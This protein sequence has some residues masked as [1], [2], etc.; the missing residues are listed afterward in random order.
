MPGEEI[1]WFPGHMLK[2]KKQIL[3][4]VRDVDIVVELLD[5]RAPLATQNPM[6]SEI[7]PPSLPRLELLTKSDLS[8]AAVTKGWQ[9]RFE[10]EGKRALALSLKDPRH[11]KASVMKAVAQ[12]PLSRK[13][14]S[15][16]AA[17]HVLVIGVPNVGKSTLINALIGKRKAKVENRPALTR[18]LELIRGGEGLSVP[19][20]IFDTPGVLWPKLDNEDQ[21]RLLSLLGN[22][23]STRYDDVELG[24]FAL[25]RMQSVGELTGA[26]S[27]YASA[28]ALLS[29]GDFYGALL[30]IGAAGRLQK[31]EDATRAHGAQVLI[32][33][34]QDGKIPSLSFELP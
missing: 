15:Y 5:S 1:N 19:L 4:F 23:R 13:L 14:K 11:A 28:E 26:I 18:N 6:L 17:R 31:T 16:A 8:S 27:R 20:A 3:A 2:A 22:I 9:K 33:D 21:A 30:A 29:S 10:N 25:R 7:L 12:M 24:E 32:K 34:I